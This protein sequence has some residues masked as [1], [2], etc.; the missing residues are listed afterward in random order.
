[1]SPLA[2][3]PGGDARDFHERGVVLYPDRHRREGSYWYLLDA[4]A[5][6]QRDG[7]ERHGFVPRIAWSPD[8]RRIGIV[9]YDGV[10]TR[11]VVLDVSRG[12]Q[13]VSVAKIPIPT[14]PFLAPGAATRAGTPGARDFRLFVKDLAFTEDGAGIVVT[15]YP[16]ARFRADSL[17]L[18]VSAGVR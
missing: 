13:L 11:L 16:T 14:G 5:A 9:E 10:E 4:D 6:S 7:L 1:M 17:T 15:S 18:P 2:A 12:L 3:S 8:S